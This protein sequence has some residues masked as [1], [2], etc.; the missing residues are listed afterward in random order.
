MAHPLK[1]DHVQLIPGMRNDLTRENAPAGTLYA[2]QNVRYGKSGGI[3]IRRGTSLVP[4]ATVGTTHEIQNHALSYLS[5]AGGETALLGTVEGKSFALD[6][7]GQFSFCG[8]FST[9]L[10]IARTLGLITERDSGFGETR[11]G[12]ASNPDGYTL[13]AAGNGGGTITSVIQSSDGTRLA[14]NTAL[15]TKCAAI[16]VDDS[17]VLVVQNSTDLTAYVYTVTAGVPAVASASIATLDVNTRNWD[18]APGPPTFWYLIR[19]TNGTTLTLAS[20]NLTPAIVNAAIATNTVSGN[21][22]CTVAFVAANFRIWMGWCDAGASSVRARAYSSISGTAVCAVTTIATGTLPPLIGPPPSGSTSSAV[23][24]VNNVS[25]SAPSLTYGTLTL[26]AN[27]ANPATVASDSIYF[28]HALSKPD[29]GQRSWVV[30]LPTT[31]GFAVFGAVFAQRFLLL[32]WETETRT[33]ASVQLATDVFEQDLLIGFPAGDLF[34]AVSEQSGICLAALPRRLRIT[35]GTVAAAGLNGLDLFKYESVES[36]ASRSVVSIGRTAVV[37]GQPVE[38]FANA[39]GIALNSSGGGLPTSR[40]GSSEI[41]FSGAPQIVSLVE[42]SSGGGLATTGTYSYTVVTE[43]IDMFGRRHRSTPSAPKTI[44]LTGVNNAVTI[45]IT[46]PDYGERWARAIST[47]PVHHVYR[48]EDDGQVHFRVT[49][50][51]GAPGAY[52]PGSGTAAF[53]DLMS[54]ANLTLIGDAVYVD[55]ALC[56]YSLAP[57]CRFVWRDE[58]RVW[59]GGLWEADQVA[60]SLDLI[61]GQPIEFSDFEGLN[62][63]VFRVLVGEP[64]TGGA[65]QDGVNYVFGKR[66]IYAFSGDGPDRQGNGDFSRPRVITTEVGCVDYRSVIA[67]SLGIFFQSDRGIELLPRGGGNPVFVGA[68][69]QGLLDTFPIVLGAALYAD[70]ASRTVRFLVSNSNSLVGSAVAVYDLDIRAWSYDI[71][72]FAHSVI[73]SWPTGI[74]FGFADQSETECACIESNDIAYEDFSNPVTMELITHTMRPWGLTGY[75]RLN[76]AQALLSRASGA[77]QLTFT[78]TVDGADV[79]KSFTLDSTSGA[80]YRELTIVRECTGFYFTVSLQRAGL[81]NWP[82]I[83]GITVEAQQL[84]GSRRLPASEQ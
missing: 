57:S 60:C 9:C 56:D 26:P 8:R 64:V 77:D 13:I 35:S 68:G 40:N 74:V 33:G 18:I 24:T 83:H 73:G 10:P 38:T 34:F 4:S 84:E 27:A 72:P 78:A 21:C 2:A 79:S 5:S 22:R 82:T 50:G 37:A 48:T 43:W 31:T 15:G 3:S 12:V 20:L 36:H 1:T 14:Y 23:F 75:G 63:P 30:T 19:Q 32:A 58:K 7:N 53:L 52:A 71:Y 70:S 45:T 46:C 28:V 17:L 59:F 81:P 47:V 80:L 41:G 62:G 42:S 16:C 6:T 54:D 51:A 39:F 61:P 44:T 11:Y 29:S 76:S 55:A 67:T 66:A 69:I 49:P 65:Y 25:S